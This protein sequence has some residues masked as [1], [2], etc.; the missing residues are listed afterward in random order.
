M[1]EEAYLPLP[2]T[3]ADNQI[4]NFDA[5]IKHSVQTYSPLAP[6]TGIEIRLARETRIRQCVNELHSVCIS[7]PYLNCCRY[8]EFDKI[9]YSQDQF[10]TLF[11]HIPDAIEALQKVCT[12]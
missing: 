9:G 7:R 2:C 1:A 6:S 11:R 5:H 3:T 12:L 4:L 8:N 10:H